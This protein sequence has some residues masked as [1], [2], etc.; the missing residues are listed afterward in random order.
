MLRPML[1][2]LSRFNQTVTFLVL[3]KDNW[4]LLLGALAFVGAPM[5]QWWRYVKLTADNTSW[6]VYP[7]LALVACFAIVG[8]WAIALWL[9]KRVR[10]M[11]SI[12]V[13]VEKERQ[14]VQSV[15][16]QSMT[17]AAQ[18]NEL[19]G[20]HQSKPPAIYDHDKDPSAWQRDNHTIQTN[21]VQKFHT[22]Y[23]TKAHALLLISSQYGAQNVR[24]ISWAF[25]ALHSHSVGEIRNMLM[26]SA[27]KLNDQLRVPIDGVIAGI[28]SFEEQRRLPFN[29][30]K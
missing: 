3:V 15:I 26:E 30:G 11:S 4:L 8:L 1:K 28:P 24:D 27:M 12:D 6:L 10:V 7:F 19:L 20:E 18:L 16:D 13:R 9:K 2:T 14:T 25:G 5:W 23:A 17:L 22:K 29:D 21:M